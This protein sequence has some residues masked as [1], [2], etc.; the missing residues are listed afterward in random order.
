[1]R[2]E[3][4]KKAKIT[5]I[6]VACVVVVLSLVIAIPNIYLSNLGKQ[7]QLGK[8]TGYEWQASDDYST[9]KVASLDMGEDDYKVLVL[10]DIHLKNHGTFAKELGINYLLDGASKIALDKLV[11][12]QNPD[13]ILIL[14]DSVQTDR[15]DIELARI[16]K[17]FDSYKIPWAPVFGNH[18]DEG[19]ADKSKLA[20]VFMDS[21]Y[22]L[23][24]FGPKDLHGAGNYV[25]S[26]ERNGKTEYAMFMMDSGSS[27]EFDD[28]TDG[29]N[30]KQVEWYEWN[31][32]AFKQKGGEYPKNMSFFHIPVAIYNE[33]NDG[34]LF[35]ERGEESYSQ[36]NTDAILNSMLEH[37]G[38]HIL[39]GHD[40]SNNFIK[41]Y[42][43]MK[44]GYAMKS[45]YNCYFKS[46]MT[47]GKLLTID[48][49]N[50][51]TERLVK[52]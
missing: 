47:G 10:T 20:E 27:K 7:I 31:M 17:W 12:K 8:A 32:E 49:D 51:V 43:G 40:H 29:I 1:M 24:D 25:L 11:K 3:L 2:K 28:K 38:T 44:I 16:V 36:S 34:F 45:S 52:F 6:V 39:V 19:R 23:F 41:E 48:K 37:N 26:F 4:S 35:G 9:Q 30:Q 14:G 5:L 18:D 22:C 21:Q 46:G 42:K 33:F 15:N 50:K 13:L